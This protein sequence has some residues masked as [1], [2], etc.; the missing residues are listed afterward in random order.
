MVSTASQPSSSKGAK[1]VTAIIYSLMLLVV[2][3]GFL[4]IYLF[5]KFLA[6]FLSL[7][8][9]SFDAGRDTPWASRLSGGFI[10]MW[11]V[12]RHKGNA[13]A[14]KVLLKNAVFVTASFALTMGAALFM[15]DLNEKHCVISM[16]RKSADGITVT[17]CPPPE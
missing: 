9:T 3:C 17:M 7:T 14:R 6:S 13:H 10:P 4:T 1:E 8:S 15:T 5:L 16:T 11:R 2:V 12:L